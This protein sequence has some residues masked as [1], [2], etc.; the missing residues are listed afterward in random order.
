[1][2]ITKITTQKKI[3]AEFMEPHNLKQET[4]IRPNQLCTC[5]SNEK[6]ITHFP[7]LIIHHLSQNIVKNLLKKGEKKNSLNHIP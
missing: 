4:F 2:G 5:Q 6:I 1:M 3:R 7:E